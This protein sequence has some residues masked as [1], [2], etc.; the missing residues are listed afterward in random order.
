MAA[1]KT[2]IDRPEMEL[3]PKNLLSLQIDAF[4]FGQ[5]MGFLAFTDC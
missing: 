2:S 1:E 3:R 4:A 5:Y